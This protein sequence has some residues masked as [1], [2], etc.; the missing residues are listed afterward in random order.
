MLRRAHPG[1]TPTALHVDDATFVRAPA[2]LVYRALTDVRRWPTWWSGCRVQDRGAPGEDRFVIEWTGAWR[3][4]HRVQATAG[5]WRHAHGFTL[6]LA[7]D[8]DGQLEFWLDASHA[9]TTVHHLLVA[10]TTAT[11]PMTLLADHRRAA[12]R[13]LWGVKDLVQLDVRASIGL[14]P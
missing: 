2:T 8:L 9:G 10:T 5:A 4:V 6:S 13:G 7:G 11:R 3:R 1:T 14:D 12:R